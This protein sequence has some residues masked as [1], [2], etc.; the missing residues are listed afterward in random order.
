[1]KFDHKVYIIKYKNINWTIKFQSPISRPV[2]DRSWDMTFFFVC[3]L[4]L[5]SFEIYNKR[6]SKNQ[7][8]KKKV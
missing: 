8:N 1:M 2:T 3:K 7:N 5:N 6:I 4:I